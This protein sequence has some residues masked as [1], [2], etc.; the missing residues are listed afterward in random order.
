MLCTERIFA[1]M[2]RFLCPGAVLVD[3]KI[4]G[5]DLEDAASRV[6][7]EA[8]RHAGPVGIMGLSLGAIVAMA[9]CIRNP[10][11]FAAA[12]LM[13]TNP[14][15]PRPEQTAG[16]KQ[17]ARRNAIEGPALIAR[18][19]APALFATGQA[20]KSL[21]LL[22]EEM[23]LEVGA[24][25]FAR[26]LDIQLSRT[27]LRP[28]LMTLKMPSLV[29]AGAEDQLCGRAVHIDIATKMQDAELH[30]FPGLGHLFP[31]ENPALAASRIHTW[32]QRRNL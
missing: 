3:L 14:R 4:I 16:W 19:S 21:L 17:L 10:E 24:G 12:I 6:V 18:D 8:A 20:Q 22:A 7:T 25:E 26:Q 1:D 27:D 32:T 9:A 5:E 30:I 23:A 28:D 31:L 2:D 13:S 29:L 15:K 11:T